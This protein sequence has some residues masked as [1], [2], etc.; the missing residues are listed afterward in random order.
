[1]AAVAAARNATRRRLAPAIRQYSVAALQRQH[2]ARVAE[3]AEAVAYRNPHSA[4]KIDD[5]Q[6]V[7]Y[8]I[9]KGIV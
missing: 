9:G 3:H 2:R 5:T 4:T 6:I 7:L 8:G 1:M